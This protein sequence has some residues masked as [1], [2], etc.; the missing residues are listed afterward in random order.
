[1]NSNTYWV[2]FYSYKGGVGRSM[3]LSNIA[4]QLAYQGRNVLMI[5][6]DL[7]APGLDSFKEF[8]VIPSSPGV[9]EYISSYLKSGNPSPVE[10]YVQRCPLSDGLRGNLWLMPSG[11]KD[12]DYNKLRAR[13][14]WNDIYDNRAGS[15]FIENWKAE[16]EQKYKPDYVFIDSRTGLTE[17]GGVCTLHFPNLVVLLFGLNDQNIEGAARVARIIE[18]RN[19]CAVM[20]V[21]TPVPNLPVDEHPLKE[22]FEKARD[23]IGC[24][25][26]NMIRYYHPAALAERLFVLESASSP[27]CDDYID[28]SNSILQKNTLGLDKLIEDLDKACASMDDELANTLS[29]ILNSRFSESA[30][31]KFAVAKK[32]RVFGDPIGYEALLKEAVSN[33]ASFEPALIPY[34]SVCRNRQ[35]YEELVLFLGEIIDKPE[36]YVLSESAIEDVY[37]A[38]AETSMTLGQYENAYKVYNLLC[39]DAENNPNVSLETKLGWVFNRAEA[40]RRRDRC[41]YPEDWKVVVGLYESLMGSSDNFARERLLNMKQAM[42][43]AYACV[44]KV[45]YAISLLKEAEEQSVAGP[46]T[47]RVFLVSEYQYFSLD[48][49]QEANKLML[50]SLEQRELWDGVKLSNVCA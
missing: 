23:R 18:K 29:H 35:Q 30:E 36:N 24:D 19:V 39:E 44:G 26:K 48:K 33:D 7:E 38:Y 13:I 20:P 47:S 50:S 6:F 27:I 16:I 5:D 41:I 3:A 37:M 10:G 34:I 25:V 17:V 45:S 49:W 40:R 12:H 32:A 31:A 42:H 1:M 9:V 4:A 8:G 11:R 14:D 21:A 15:L 28:I 43:I 22:R 2:T 46:I